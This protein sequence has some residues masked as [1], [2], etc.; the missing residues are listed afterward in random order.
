MGTAVEGDFTRLGEDTRT[1]RTNRRSARLLGHESGMCFGIELRGFPGS[2]L[3]PGIQV[4][5]SETLLTMCKVRPN[6]RCECPSTNMAWALIIFPGG[7]RRDWIFR[8][9]LTRF[10]RPDAA[11]CCSLTEPRFVQ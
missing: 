10:L 4:M 3:C 1:G 5:G 7:I 8:L 6:T 11:A 2:L 9:G